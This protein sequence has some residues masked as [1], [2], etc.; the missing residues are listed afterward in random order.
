VSLNPGSLNQVQENHTVL[1]R[2]LKVG[3]VGGE[4][5][6]DCTFRPLLLRGEATGQVSPQVLQLSSSPVSV[7]PFSARAIS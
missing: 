5:M 4:E 3:P 7:H 6:L 2:R 1:K